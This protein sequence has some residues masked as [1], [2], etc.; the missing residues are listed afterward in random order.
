[1]TGVRW[2]I[3]NGKAKSQIHIATDIRPGRTHCRRS[4]PIRSDVIR[5]QLT[6]EEVQSFGTVC[7]M[8]RAEA[9][10]NGAR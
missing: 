3:H 9:L 1:M 6:A 2:T 4:I 7:G 10:R 5:E 8:C